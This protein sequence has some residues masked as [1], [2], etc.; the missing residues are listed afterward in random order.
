MLRNSR[1]HSKFGQVWV[2]TQQD[3]S[4]ESRGFC[5]LTQEPRDVL[6]EAEKT[7]RSAEFERGEN[8]I[9]SKTVGQIVQAAQEFSM[10][11][12]LVC[13]KTTHIRC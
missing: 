3:L 5:K 13:R 9:K 10:N 6:S 11:K 8:R 4:E 7:I 2:A 1:A 12:R